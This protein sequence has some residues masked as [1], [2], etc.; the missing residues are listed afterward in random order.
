VVDSYPKRAADRERWIL[1]RRAPKNRLDPRRPYAFITELERAANGEIV[2]VATIFLTNRE[3][4]WRCAYCDLWKNTLD[5]P[6]PQGAVP[7]Q[8]DF[9]L[10]NLPPENRRHLKLYNSGSFFDSG[11]IPPADF[12]DIAARVREF[13]H[14]VV[15]CH[16]GL[17]G[18]RIL[19]F[20]DLLPV[21]TT[22]EIAMGL[23]T[24]HPEV[25]E[26]LNKRMTLDDF[27]RATAFLRQCQIATR[28][29]ILVKPPFVEEEPEA[30]FWAKKSLD[31][32]VRLGVAVAVLIPTRGGNGAL[33]A[34]AGQGHFS[35]PRLATLENAAAYGIGLRAGRVFADIWDLEKF[36]DCPDCART[37]KARLEAM[38][39]DQRVLPPVT[40][41][42]CG[43]CEPPRA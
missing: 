3:C 29:F 19:R 20:R 43:G 33:E 11:A 35:P 28:A 25:L 42:V 17:I 39:L 8:I 2:P 40:C 38:N 12:A 26:K 36:A 24:A 37:R 7:A 16:P 23:E 6:T 9:A 1:S 13:E 27:A 21:H 10:V 30:L 15:E 32:A 4:P 5:N 14:I 41:P 18:D 22:L 31:F 34:L